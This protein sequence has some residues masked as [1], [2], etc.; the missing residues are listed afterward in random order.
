[1]E[2]KF[3]ISVT[4]FLV[5]ITLLFSIRKNKEIH[6]ALSLIDKNESIL[7]DRE[8]KILNLKE[9]YF[10]NIFLRNLSI[11]GTFLG[12]NNAEVPVK[13][14]INPDRTIAMFI[15][16]SACLDC[17]RE[18]ISLLFKYF[19]NDAI[20]IRLGHI[21]DNQEFLGYRIWGLVG[22]SELEEIV[23]LK[24]PLIALISIDNILQFMFIP[25]DSDLGL[26]EKYLIKLKN[27]LGQI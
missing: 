12:L 17:H 7:K 3:L 10:E 20:I 24:R 22:C 16:D 13:D 1:M 21:L 18:Y 15:S 2:R 6:S 9:I 5:F 27:E 26:F 8:Q 19:Y 4:L 11:K 14:V 25:I 23:N